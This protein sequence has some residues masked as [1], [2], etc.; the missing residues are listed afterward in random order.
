MRGHTRIR[1]QVRLTLTLAVG[2]VLLMI[3]A[4]QGPPPTEYLLEV[5]REVTRVVVV[6]GT[7]LDG[8]AVAAGETPIATPTPP[9]AQG[10]TS[11]VASPTVDPFPTPVVEQI[12]VS[13]EIFEN[14][15]MFYLQP[16]L[17]IWVMVNGTGENGGQWMIYEDN[18][19][20]GSLEFDPNIEAPAGLFQPERGFG[21]LWRENEDV[22]EAL[23]WAL[24][25]EQG[26]VTD[27]TFVFGG[28]VNADNEY[29]PGP[30]YHTLRSFEG[31]TFIFDTSDMTWRRAQDS[32]QP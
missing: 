12:I 6:T 29:I 25:P 22:R 23:G 8:T 1:F 17:E 16:N 4:C 28:E 32:A 31:T 24:G 7:P 19:E 5:T 15:R 11:P 9:P 14:G 10:T 26:H 2:F 3:A 21:K 20:E 30:G 13:E 18:W 27:Y